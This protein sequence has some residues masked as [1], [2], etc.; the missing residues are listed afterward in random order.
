ML[1]GKI[2][3]ENP[4]YFC[5]FFA[6]HSTIMSVMSFITFQKSFGAEISKKNH[7]DLVVTHS[8]LRWESNIQN[9]LD[10]Q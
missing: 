4:G 2:R 8:E 7:R 6:I 10:L 3:Y 5:R 1:D 9:I